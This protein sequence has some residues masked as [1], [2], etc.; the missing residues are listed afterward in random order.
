MTTQERFQKFISPEPMSGC[1]LWT[2]ALTDKGYARI[3]GASKP[4]KAHRLS[5]ELARGPIPD[6]LEL[7]HL[8][9]VRCCVNPAHLEPVTHAENVRRS[10]AA[11]GNPGALAGSAVQRAKTHCPSGHEYNEANTYRLL[12]SRFCRA[13]R[14]RAC[15]E[16]SRRKREARR[17]CT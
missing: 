10:I 2:G 5:Y 4:V 14:N 16:I 13:C 6:G 9:R 8:C 12:G 7:D 3:R 1:W 11:I 17:N 15:R